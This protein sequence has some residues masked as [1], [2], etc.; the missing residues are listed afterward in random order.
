M[1]MGFLYTIFVTLCFLIIFI[2]LLQKSKGSLGLV[3]SIGNSSVIFGGSG[4]HDLFQKITWF[5]VA[6][7][8]LGSLGLSLLKNRSVNRSR[9]LDNSAATL[10]QS[11]P[12]PL[13]PTQD[14]PSS[15]SS[16][17][18]HTEQPPATAEPISE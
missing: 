4:G 15:A 14:A 6:S 13:A 16:A 10:V 3:G 12:S 17:S 18:D 9:Y 5:F 2:V 1:L 11:T 8:M 7:F